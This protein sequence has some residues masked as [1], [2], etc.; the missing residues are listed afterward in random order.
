MK[1]KHCG[2]NL[3]IEDA[4]C[5]YCGEPNPFAVRHQHEMQRFSREFQ[6]T[7]KNV[8]EQ[9]S[10][11]NRRTVRITILAILVAACAVMAL[12]CAR[13][14]DIRYMLEEKR[15]GADAEKYRQ[16]IDGMMEE[17]DYTGVYV[18]MNQNHLSWTDAL[19]EYDAVYVTSMYYTRL[20]ENVMILAEK[21][22]N[23]ERY[24]YYDNEELIEEIAMEINFIY[25]EMKEDEYYPERYTDD[26]K[27]Y[28]NDLAET[29]GL[30]LVRY[31]HITEEEA[32]QFPS[33]SKARRTV[34]LEDAYES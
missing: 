22:G 25:E 26:K 31:M 9:S 30:L 28:M 17:R 1:C 19:K 32:E 12:L 14:D 24:S 4:Y 10:R 29:V 5:P 23:E 21:A 7:K 11:F 2:N 18:Y 3:Q 16:T 20:Y 13:A 6:E 8:L 15:I 34:L 33:L 27:A